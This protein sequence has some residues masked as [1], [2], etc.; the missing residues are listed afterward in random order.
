MFQP[1]LLQSFL[2][3]APIPPSPA[4]SAPRPS[5]RLSGLYHSRGPDAFFIRTHSADATVRQHTQRPF[6][7][8]AALHHSSSTAVTE[9]HAQALPCSLVAHTHTH[10]R[11]MFL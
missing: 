2:C 5:C 8:P 9:V 10:A 6:S 3:S 11:T 7:Q 1:P 4:D